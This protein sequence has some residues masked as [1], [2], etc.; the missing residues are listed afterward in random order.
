MGLSTQLFEMAT[1]QYRNEVGDEKYRSEVELL[2][3][4]PEKFD[5]RIWSRED[6]EEIV[7]WK[8]H[9]ALPDF[10]ENDRGVDETIEKALD[11]Q[12]LSEAVDALRG[13]HGVQV[14]MASAFLM[15]MDPNKY[16]VID[17]RAWKA[18]RDLGYVTADY[19]NQSTYKYVLYLGICKA[20]ALEHGVSL[21]NLDRALWVLGGET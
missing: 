6:L 20:L 5:N 8:S 3:E 15:F 4:L 21:R 9:R 11:A 19:D 7:Q 10:G 18:F 12:E 17:E 16:T 13:L 1:E 14:P 2:Q